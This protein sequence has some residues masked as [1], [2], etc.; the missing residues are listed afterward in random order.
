M[1]AKTLAKY[2]QG[3]E[4]FNNGMSI[5][6]ICIELKMAHHPFSKWLKENGVVVKNNH[7]GYEERYK[8]GMELYLNG[9][10]LTKASQ[11]VGSSPK[12]LSKYIK[13][14]GI[15]ITNPTVKRVIKD[16]F[17]KVIDNEKKAYWLGFIYADGYIIETISKTGKVKSMYLGIGLQEG[18]REH[19]QKFLSDIEYVN[20][21]VR[22]KLVKLNG[23]EINTV[24]VS[25]NHTNMCRDL[26]KL[27]VTPRKS[28]TLTFPSTEIVPSHLLPH[29][30]RGYLDGDGCVEHRPT[31]T[32]GIRLRVSMVGTKWFLEGLMARVP[33]FQA[34]IRGDKRSAIPTSNNVISYSCNRAN[35]I[36]NYL[37]K[38]ANVYLD[39]KYNK[40]L[41]FIENVE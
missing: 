36:A 41:P 29:F 27:G 4:L 10:S 9:V 25:I 15:E 14:Q 32:D 31:K 16:D 24:R 23:K 37:Y 11:E 26:I 5:R 18:D 34:N 6:N 39:R 3:K 13:S 20:G 1:K 28:H 21:K 2:K 40:I 8:R 35:T 19:L 17:F 30:I 38:N 7:D 22:N 33:I 12:R